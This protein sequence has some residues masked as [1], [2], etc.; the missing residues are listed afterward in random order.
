MNRPSRWA[1][2]A[3]IGVIY[4]YR[5]L[6]SPLIGSRCRFVP[7]CSEYA[8]GA[9]RRYGLFRGLWLTTRRL[10]RCHPWGGYGYDPVPDDDRHAAPANDHGA[11]RATPDD[12]ISPRP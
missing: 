12:E 6:I 10:L 11:W 4:L 9:L 5:Y 1:A 7:T 8:I 2:S 3:L